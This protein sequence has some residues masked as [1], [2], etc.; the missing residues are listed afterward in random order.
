[1]E[2]KFKIGFKLYSTDTALIPDSAKLLKEAFFDYIELYI[3]PGSF[4]NTITKWK[5]FECPY[6]IHAPHSFH[7]INLAKAEMRENNLINF[8]EAQLFADELDSDIIIVHGGNDGSLDETIRQIGLMHENRIALENKPM[9]GLN[10]EFCVG[11]SPDEFRKI[12]RAGI[13]KGIVLDF[14]HAI[15]YSA[16]SGSDYH[17]VIAEFTEFSPLLFHLSDGIYSSHAD[18]HLN[19]GEGEFNIRELLSFIPQNARLSLETPRVSERG[20]QDFADEV[21][22]L[23]GIMDDVA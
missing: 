22:L 1:M 6:V 12:S 16:F 23:N 18:V 21:R 10:G 4:E 17:A 2:Y 7:G 11:C 5:G 13:L 15:Y 20:L 14:G 3:I 8:R 19:I 9:R